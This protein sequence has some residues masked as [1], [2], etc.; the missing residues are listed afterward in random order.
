M[1]QNDEF[2]LRELLGAD[3]DLGELPTPEDTPASELTPT[4]LPK[5]EERPESSWAKDPRYSNRPPEVERPH[6]MAPEVAEEK[7][8]EA[9][10]VLSPMINDNDINI[11]AKEI[12][13]M[14]I[15][16][17]LGDETT[18]TL[19][20]E[21]Y[22][23]FNDT[24]VETK[25]LE[26]EQLQVI[27]HRMMRAIR[28]IKIAMNGIRVNELGKLAVIP[29]S[30]RRLVRERDADFMAK[31]KAV[32]GDVSITKAKTPRAK[33]SNSGLTQAEK[34]IKQFVKLN[35]NDETIRATLISVGTGVPENV[36]ELINKYRK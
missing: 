20:Q 22:R 35:M 31:R 24:Q 5:T 21:Y 23:I 25:D 27:R 4:A 18:E 17:A 8:P 28:R 14:N 13:E 1:S 11:P 7:F 19:D 34:Q 12:E 30:R 33:S 29:E 26:A 36:Q 32:E 2:D 10:S 16:G 15:S 9:P 6:P 3:G